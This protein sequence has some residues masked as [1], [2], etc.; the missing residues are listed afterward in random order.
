MKANRPS[1]IALKLRPEDMRIFVA[2]GSARTLTDAAEELKM[3]LFT[4]SR[5]LKRIE[6]TAEL[7]L[8][9]RD[10]AGLRLTDV[11]DEYMRACHAVLQAHEAANSILLASKTEPE[12]VLHVAA[13]LTF[14][15]AFLS[16]VLS[17]FL[18]SFPKL[19]VE[20]FLFSDTR[21]EH[22]ASYDIF[23]R[24]GMPGE[25]RHRLKLFPSIRQS[26]YAN[27]AYL[28]KR[29]EPTHASDLEQ[30]ECITDQLN[31]SPWLLTR[32]G[33]R[34]LVHFT[35]RVVIADPV[36]LARFAVKFGGITML[37][38]WLAHDYVSSGE[39]VELLPDWTPTPVVFC[40]L[41]T[42]HLS[43]TSKEHTFLSFLNSVVGGPKD[44][45]CQ[46]LD[47]RQFFVHG[48]S[49]GAMPPA[50]LHGRGVESPRVHR[51]IADH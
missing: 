27:P 1:K 5:A 10:G 48:P 22:K 26:L 21:Q 29:P 42:G 30:L 41:Y 44:P 15:Q 45:R 16:Q 31:P 28:A 14:G 23:L 2:I 46:G 39:L 32:A 12:G 35:P 11:G 38:R 47:P 3:P 19:Q 36:S 50:L 8:I 33:E 20:I 37:P 24:A 9:R 25:S 49:T 43:P 7:G 34:V 6:A 40:A 13:P 17:E 51:V 4:V 18:A